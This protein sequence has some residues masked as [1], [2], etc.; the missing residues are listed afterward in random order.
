MCTYKSVPFEEHSK[1]AKIN[2]DSLQ[3]VAFF[4]FWALIFFQK[5]L[6]SYSLKIIS[7]YLYMQCESLN[8]TSHNSNFLITQTFEHGPLPGND[9]SLHL[10]QTWT[11]NS[12]KNS[13]KWNFPI[14]LFTCQ[15][16]SQSLC[17]SQITVILSESR[18]NGLDWLED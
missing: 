9:N 10:T 5:T 4:V 3:N 7:M 8:A 2:E 1:A 12:N 13:S 17:R 14:Q 11:H 16:R 15:C 6:L 18:K